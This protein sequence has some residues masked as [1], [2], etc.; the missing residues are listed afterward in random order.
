MCDTLNTPVARLQTD[1]TASGMI[2]TEMGVYN[3]LEGH[4]L[5]GSL[6]SDIFD[7]D[8]IA[9]NN[10]YTLI[11]DST[12]DRHTQH[13]IPG[14]FD[15]AAASRLRTSGWRT[16]WCVWPSSQRTHPAHTIHLHLAPPFF[17]QSAINKS[18]GIHSSNRRCSGALIPRASAVRASGE[19]RHLATRAIPS[20]SVTTSFQ[21]LKIYLCT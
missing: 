12:L 16:R 19:R 20:P 3:V 1:S 15:F 2:R 11:L 18:L 14:D 7:N 6:R 10:K 17:L 4:E 9:I 5:H 13:R 21:S 8:D